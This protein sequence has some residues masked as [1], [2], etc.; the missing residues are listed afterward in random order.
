MS[1]QYLDHVQ[2]HTVN[3]GLTFSK[4]HFWSTVQGLYGSGLRTGPN[5]SLSLPDHFTMDLGA[6]YEFHGKSWLTQF[7]LSGNLLNIFD[8]TY[9]ITIANGF[10]GSHYAAGREFFIRLVKVL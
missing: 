5:N 3:S 4:N 1:Y 6:G 7:K 10:N 9:P 2:V 8:N